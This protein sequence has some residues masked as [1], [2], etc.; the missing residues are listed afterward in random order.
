MLAIFWLIDT[1]IGIYIFMLIGSAILSWLV[2]FN[3][4]NT[5]NKFVYMVGDFL[6]RVTEPAL[7]PIRRV[8]PDLGG[9]DVSPIILILIL[10]FANMLIQ[11]DLRA[12]L[13]GY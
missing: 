2:A 13:L 3:V 6:Y 5:S 11:T 10:Q 9:I 7:R 8:I 4:V 1:V 12:A